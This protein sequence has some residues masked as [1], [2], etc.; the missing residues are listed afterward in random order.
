MRGHSLRIAVMGAT[1]AVLAV[2]APAMRVGAAT[3]TAC[4]KTSGVTVIVDFAAF[5]H[6]VARGCASGQPS[7]ALAAM[8][9]AGFET[10]GTTQYG[11]AFLCRIDDLPE[12]KVEACAVTPPAKSSWS[13]YWARPTDAA[14][15]YSRTGV[16]SY[17][18]PPGTIV[19]FAFGDLAK[20]GVLP[21]AA[22]RT[23]G[24]PNTTTTAPTPRTTPTAIADPTIAPAAVT[25][26][27][28]PL[29]TASTVVPS[30][31]LPRAVP[32]HPTASAP[33]TTTTTT[34]T[35]AARVVD[36]PAISPVTV[37]NRSGSPTGA[38]LGGA[39]VLG[40]GVAAGLTI[41]ARRH[42]TT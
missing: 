8:R 31:T 34:T 40:L 36:R 2:A 21:S 15:T 9:T 20:P 42:R 5:H 18:P 22:I 7:T 14:W 10:A 17:R 24:T 39:L 32:L 19:A 35:A 30:T 6:G 26:T 28:P 13:F 1:I 11:D 4:T 3:S 29:P 41:R 25:T 38:L 12:P 27:T 16:L 37:K 23:T 33:A